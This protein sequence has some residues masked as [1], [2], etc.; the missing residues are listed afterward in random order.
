M[1]EVWSERR[2]QSDRQEWRWRW[3]I[4]GDHIK[5]ERRIEKETECKKGEKGE[6]EEREEREARRHS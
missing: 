6:V 5:G 2:A 4:E 1:G 3:F